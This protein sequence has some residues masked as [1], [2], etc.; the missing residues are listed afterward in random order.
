MYPYIFHL[1]CISN[2][3]KRAAG[4]SVK[5]T[6]KNETTRHC[7]IYIDDFLEIESLLSFTILSRFNLT[8]YSELLNKNRE[9]MEIRW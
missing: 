6:R 3:D 9:N 5:T 7:Y 8:E 1:L 4:A 2:V